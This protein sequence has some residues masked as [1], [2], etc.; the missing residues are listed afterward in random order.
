MDN[1]VVN[2]E[3]SEN[4][5]LNL[6]ERRKSQKL[7]SEKKNSKWEKSIQQELEEVKGILNQIHSPRDDKSLKT[8]QENIQ[9]GKERRA[10]SQS[11]TNSPENNNN[12]NNNNSK[13]QLSLDFSSQSDIFS[14]GRKKKTSGK[15]SEARSSSTAHTGFFKRKLEEF[16]ERFS[17]LLGEVQYD[18]VEG[19][20]KD[21]EN[22]IYS[23]LGKKQEKNSIGIRT[24]YKD[25]TFL[26]FLQAKIFKK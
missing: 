21:V 23:R 17:N 24:N 20:Q 13:Q 5:S 14:S 8:H 1:E 12:N 18:D 10:K 2:Q 19:I 22:I 11:K 4:T 3:Q 26:N 6:S 25:G 16:S 7:L 9:S 15:Q